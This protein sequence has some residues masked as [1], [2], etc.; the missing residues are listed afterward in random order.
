MSLLG[1]ESFGLCFGFNIRV[2]LSDRLFLGEK[3]LGS[4]IILRVEMD[5]FLHGVWPI[6][7]VVWLC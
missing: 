7:F 5:G 3:L 1:L 2:K 4:G 6:L